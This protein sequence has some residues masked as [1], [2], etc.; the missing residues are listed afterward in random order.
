MRCGEMQAQQEGVLRL[1]VVLDRLSRAV[2]EKVRHVSV[3]IDRDLLLEE[4][5]GGTRI[6]LEIVRRPREDPEELVVAALERTELREK[7]HMPL[8]DEACPVANLLDE[9]RQRR[10]ARGQPG[11]LWALWNDRLLEAGRETILIAPRDQ[12]RSRRRAHGRIRIALSETE[13]LDREAVDVRRHV[14][15]LA[16]AAQ[17]RVAEVVGHDEDDVRPAGLRPTG[18]AQNQ[19]RE[20]QRTD[21]GRLDESAAGNRALAICHLSSSLGQNQF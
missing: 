16:V 11:V 13:P 20:G 7:A 4:R 3:P 12:G 8:A 21:G 2:A 5:V 19:A 15:T 6:V 14:V 1:A 9:R 17:V 18:A 10:M